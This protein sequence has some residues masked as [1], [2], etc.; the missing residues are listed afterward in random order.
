MFGVAAIMW[1]SKICLFFMAAEIIK[2]LC[3]KYQSVMQFQCFDKSILEKFD[4]LVRY[5]EGSA[6]HTFLLYL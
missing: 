2:M 1:M 5:A 3:L 6:S 4:K